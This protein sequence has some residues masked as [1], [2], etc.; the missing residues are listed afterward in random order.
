MYEPPD[1]RA[2]IQAFAAASAVLLVEV[3]VDVLL[4]VAVLL[5]LAVVAA[6]LLELAALELAVLELA[7]LDVADWLMAALVATACVVVV[8]LWLVALLTELAL[9]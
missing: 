6:L 3:L 4:V 8:E 7:A 9:A 5:E 1:S 2:A